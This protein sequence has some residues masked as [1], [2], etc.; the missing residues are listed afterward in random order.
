MVERRKYRKLREAALVAQ[1]VFRASKNKVP[2]KPIGIKP[3]AGESIL[4]IGGYDSDRPPDVSNSSTA[5][6]QLDSA[7]NIWKLR[8]HL[9]EPRARHGS[10]QIETHIFIFGKISA[11]PDLTFLEF[12]SV[13]VRRGGSFERDESGEKYAKCHH[14]VLEFGKWRLD[15]IGG[16]D[17]PTILLWLRPLAWE[18]FCFW[19]G[20]PRWTVRNKLILPLNAAA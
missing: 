4:V 17:Y 10:V 15:G 9:P 1:A 16:N 11:N 7:K 13:V 14:M 5:I 8:G 3:R 20:W 2:I 19:R 18:N 6:F 12:C